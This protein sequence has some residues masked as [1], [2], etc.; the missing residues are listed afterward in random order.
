LDIE[1]KKLEI[2][3]GPGRFECHIYGGNFP[4]KDCLLR[5]KNA[6]G[7]NKTKGSKS[8]SSEFYGKAGFNDPNCL[9]CKQGEENNIEFKSHGENIK[10]EIINLCCRKYGLDRI[11]MFKKDYSPAK[12]RPLRECIS[13]LLNEKTDLTQKEIAKIINV[14]R[15]SLWS[16]LDPEKYKLAKKKEH[17][18]TNETS[19][20]KTKKETEI[21]MD[22]NKNIKTKVCTSRDCEFKG[23]EQP[24]DKEHFDENKVSLDGFAGRCKSCR[25]RVQRNR[26]KKER[27]V[28]KNAGILKTRP[29]RQMDDKTIVLDFTKNPE[30]F[31]IIKKNAED[32]LRTIEAHLTYW[33]REIW[34]NSN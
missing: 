3:N 11:A 31:K 12:L 17:K 34:M 14:S 29:E 32:E 23:K 28:L 22:E 13:Q 30:L 16:F 18:K 8:G 33:I 4:L 26:R 19:E 1:N 24:L 25:R 6:Q 27:A 5:Q 20:V 21:K 15:G 7:W 9:N 2:L 10:D